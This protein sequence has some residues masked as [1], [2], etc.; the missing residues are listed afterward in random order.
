MFVNQIPH[1]FA[2][3]DVLLP[4]LLVFAGL[5]IVS[6]LLTARLLNKVRLS[7]YISHPPVVLLSLMV[8]Y[9]ILF[10]FLFFGA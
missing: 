8:I 2:I 1:E 5:G 6:G 9:T 4:P 3:S 7:Q 10:E